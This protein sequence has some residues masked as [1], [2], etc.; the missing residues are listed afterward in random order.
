MLDRPRAAVGDE[1]PDAPPDSGGPASPRPQPPRAGARSAQT[2]VARELQRGLARGALLQGRS[3]V[4][5]RPTPSRPPAARM[6][7]TR[8]LACKHARL[9]GSTIERDVRRGGTLHS[10]RQGCSTHVGHAHGAIRPHHRRTRAVRR[11]LH[12]RTSRDRRPSTAARRA[13]TLGHSRHEP[14]S[15]APV[16]DAHRPRRHGIQAPIAGVDAGVNQGRGSP[17]RLQPSLSA[18]RL[19]D[20]WF[21]CSARPRRRSSTTH[22]ARVRAVQ[23]AQRFRAGSQLTER[24]LLG[25]VDELLGERD[26]AP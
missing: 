18:R 24:S 22:H 20:A 26:T 15:V 3:G 8:S 9:S 17:D 11:P 2:T 16:G 25:G 12:H 5:G 19:T 13:I 6:K 10:D 1:L 14:A 4:Q 21:P 7:C 23:A